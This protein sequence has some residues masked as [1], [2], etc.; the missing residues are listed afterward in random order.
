MNFTDNIKVQALVFETGYAVIGDKV[1]PIDGEGVI[2]STAD[3]EKTAEYQQEGMYDEKGNPLEPLQEWVVFGKQKNAVIFPNSRANK[4]SLADGQD[5]IYSYEVIVKLKKTLYHLL[6][7][8]GDRIWLQK[9]DGTVD[10]EMEVKGF[11]T[12]KQK[13]LK[14]WL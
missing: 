6:P 11:V 4:V 1:F 13:Y 7:K 12:L 10:K 3:D 5:F 2:S 14:L 8:E 9:A